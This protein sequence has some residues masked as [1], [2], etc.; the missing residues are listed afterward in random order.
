[1]SV[2]NRVFMSRIP[3]FDKE[4]KTVAYDLKLNVSADKMFSIAQSSANEVDDKD[5]I[6]STSNAFTLFGIDKISSGKKIIIEMSKNLISKNF[7]FT[8]P[9]K[10]T[11]IQI[12]GNI[13]ID[14]ELIEQVKKFKEKGYETSLSNLTIKDGITELLPHIDIVRIDF[15]STSNDNISMFAENLIAYKIKLLAE[16][17]DEKTRMQYAAKLGFTMF[18]GHF[19]SKT[20]IISTNDIPPFKLNSVR[21]FRETTKPEVDF[22]AL[23][24]I[25]GQ[26]VAMTYKLLKYVNS[27]YFGVRNNITSLKNA[28]TMLGE[29]EL[30]KWLYMMLTSSL[31]SDRP[32]ELVILSMTRA[33]FCELVSPFFWMSAKASENF[34]MGMFSLFDTMFGRPIEELIDDIP[35]PEDIKKTLLGVETK[36]SSI[37]SLAKYYED[38][39]FEMC[40]TLI[41]KFML[42]EKDIQQAY[43]ESVEWTHEI[44]H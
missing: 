31:G 2:K 35:L 23:C 28:V 6:K 11:I 38:G 14:E 30:R 40:S 37:L 42:D 19:F 36:H 39:N 13:D 15:M 44:Y 32:D 33:K 21:V 3:I 7:A 9:A 20:E 27:A 16:K 18:Q 29:K 10:A 41:N 8:L 4:M 24:H 34:I 26:D 22:H 25:I 5:I 43:V 1:M 12:P 17:L